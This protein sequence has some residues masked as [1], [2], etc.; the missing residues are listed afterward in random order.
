MITPGG[1]GKA[2]FI[3]RLLMEV[4]FAESGLAGVNRR[5]EVQKGALQLAA[6]VAMALIAVVGVV[7]FTGSYRGNRGYIA[8]VG[9][10]VDRLST[11][12]A[13]QPA[14][15][16]SRVGCR[17]STRCAPSTRPPTGSRRPALRS[18][19]AGDSSRAMR[20]ATPHATR[21]RAS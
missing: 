6:Y 18:R 20:S 7:V 1:R 13:R 3:E 4:M 17:V 15:L 14:R 2:Y 8:E 19:C 21:T 5:V 9:A 16:R 12:R 11:T 10:E